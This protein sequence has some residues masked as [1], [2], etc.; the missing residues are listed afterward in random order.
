MVRSLWTSL[1]GDPALLE[2]VELTGPA[3]ALPGPFAVTELA[4]EVVG[5]ATLAVAEL[6]EG[7]PP[8]GTVGVDRAHAATAFRSES[9]LRPLGWE[10]PPPWDELAGDHRATDGWVRLHTNYPHHRAACL[11]ALGVPGERAAVAAAVATRPAEDVE[12]AVVAAGGCAAALRPPSAWAAHEQGAAVAVEPVAHVDRLAPVPSA[13]LAVP[14]DLADLR[15][16]DLTRVIA[17]PTAGKVLAAHGADVVRVAPPGFDELPVVL[18]DTGA[19]KRHVELDLRTPAGRADLVALVAD[20]H[21]VVH[22]LRPGALAGL[23]L[24]EAALRAVNPTLVAVSLDAYGWT[25]P[26]AQRRGFDSLVQMSSGIAWAGSA[27]ARPTPLPCQALDHATGWLLAAAALRGLCELRGTGRPSSW[28][29]SLAR[30]AR[31]LVDLGP[32]ADPAAEP[33]DPTPHLERADTPWGPVERVRVPG[34][35]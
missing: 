28:R 5:V 13:A 7:G 6:A 23:G 15:V 4:A 32:V 11:A 3:S 25:G 31:L 20:S 30:T 8:R 14:T 1:G 34:V 26:W 24:D 10:L 33:V 18:V 22:G 19:D 21:V 17:G 27:D 9:L 16:V 2:A 12:A 29:L 35:R